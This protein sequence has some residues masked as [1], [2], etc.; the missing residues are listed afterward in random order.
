MF[1]IAANFG[2]LTWLWA[3][4]ATER[5]SAV[6]EPAGLGAWRQRFGAQARRAAPLPLAHRLALL[7]LAAPLGVWLVGWF[8]WWVGLPLAALLAVAL[9]GALGG[10]WRPRTW[11]VGGGLAAATLIWV[12]LSPV[13]G[14]FL[15]EGQDW[16]AHRATFLDL[17]GDWPV[18][19]TE[20]VDRPQPLFRYHLG[21]FI[22]PGLIGKWLG[23][24]ALNWAVPLWTW[25]GLTLLAVLF[26]HALPSLRTALLAVVV[27]VVLFSGMDALQYVLREGP[28]DGVARFWDRVDKRLSPVFLMNRDSP[29]FLEYLANALQF[30]NSPQ[31]FLAGGIGAMLILQLRGNARFLAVVGVVLVCCAFWSA[32]VAVGLVVLTVG[33]FCGE[34]ARRSIA[35]PNTLVAPV[36][37][38]VVALYFGSGTADFPHG[39]LWHL[40]PS[41]SRMACDVL[42]LYFC[43][44]G[45]LT[46]LIWRLR[47]SAVSDPIFVAALLVLLAVPWY[48]YGDYDFSELTLR[49]VVPSLF[50]L[51]YHATRILTARLP[52]AAAPRGGLAANKAGAPRDGA[53]Q[54]VVGR[55]LAFATL[56]TVLAIGALSALAEFSI[57]LRRPGWVPYGPT[58]GNMS[59]TLWATAVEQ[60][61][62]RA[63]PPLLRLLLGRRDNNS[64]SKGDLL[65]RADYDLYLRG[66][67]LVYAREVCDVDFERTTRFFLRCRGEAGSR[68]AQ[69]TPPER[70]HEF[71]LRPAHLRRGEPCVFGRRLPAWA[72]GRIRLGQTV[73][74]EGVVWEAE[75]PIGAQGRT[76]GRILRRS[77]SFFAARHKALRDA[78]VGAPAVRSFFDVFVTGDALILTRTPCVAAD[79]SA[80][81]LLHA[82]PLRPETL[83]AHR[84]RAGFDNLDF[85]FGERGALVDGECATAT[86]LPSYSL[87]RVRVGQWRE[88]QRRETQGVVLWQA[89]IKFARDAGAVD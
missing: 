30:R 8:A 63:P 28:W 58:H 80:K 45:V 6:P 22:V 11:R 62:A 12:L 57:V 9:L 70:F 89:E 67:F 81:F 61:V 23:T 29:V 75:V 86:P 59:T 25:T 3:M 83:P 13:S 37:A 88:A 54:G 64:A 31:H 17:G 53:A 69:A 42:A 71:G 32:F 24:T 38:A 27:G 49:V 33:L 36:L 82:F 84:V 48:W 1:A 65:V 52:D 74:G 87:S 60:R 47:P 68:G 66:D 20:F 34:G 15:P 10:S 76:Q 5:I 77:E 72:T 41:G 73:P 43:E 2:A 35:W 79:T 46:A 14:V 7:Y 39:W 18:Y 50:V 21:Y 16:I 51:G 78:A 44:F 19:L 26:S 55:W 40:Y 56:A 4:A 85:R